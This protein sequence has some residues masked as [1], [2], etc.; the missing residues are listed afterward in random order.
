MGHNVRK[1]NLNSQHQSKYYTS[2]SID[3]NSI[4]R[5][6]PSYRRVGIGERLCFEL[7]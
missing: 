2:S 1:K 6:L 7:V 4:T 5:S 3:F